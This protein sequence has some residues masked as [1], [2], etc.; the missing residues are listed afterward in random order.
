MLGARMSLLLRVDGPR[1]A[2]VVAGW[3]GEGTPVPVSSPACSGA[4]RSSGASSG[5][6]KA[7]PVEDFDE[8]RESQQPAARA[9]AE[10]LAIF[11]GSTGL[12]PRIGRPWCE[13]RA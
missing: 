2:V 5:A 8:I 1:E 11:S 6:G 7:V 13:R 12:T 4:T 9:A 10:G 3:S